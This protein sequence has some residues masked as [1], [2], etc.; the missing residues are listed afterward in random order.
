MGILKKRKK[1]SKTQKIEKIGRIRDQGEK[2]NGIRQ[3]QESDELL[4]YQFERG[5]HENSLKKKRKKEEIRK[6]QQN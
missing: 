4:G 3:G 5:S 6:K 2:T 1:V